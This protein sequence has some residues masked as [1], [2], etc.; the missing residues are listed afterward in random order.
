MWTFI[1]QP[2]LATA[3]V[4]FTNDFSPLLVGLVSVVWFSAAML[5]WCA[6]QSFLTQKPQPRAE[7]TPASEDSRAAA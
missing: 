4:D 5:V 6:L 7:T 3:V 1:T 2:A